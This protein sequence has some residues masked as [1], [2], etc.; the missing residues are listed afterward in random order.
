MNT[1]ILKIPYNL[2]QKRPHLVRIPLH[3]P[4]DLQTNRLQPILEVLLRPRP[5]GL[6]IRTFRPRAGRPVK[7]PL[8]HIHEANLPHPPRVVLRVR[9]RPT[10]LFGPGLHDGV[11]LVQGGIGAWVAHVPE[12]EGAVLEFQVAAWGEG[13]VRLLDDVGR[14][15][16]AGE[17]GAAVDVVE[18]GVED[19]LVLGVV[20]FEADVHGDAGMLALV[21]QDD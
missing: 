5:E 2:R 21:S 10:A 1:S 8:N 4:H 16:E 15:F 18:C 3:Q 17:E 9:P 6:V 7:L 20:D 14:V 19:P 12:W 11:P 13:V